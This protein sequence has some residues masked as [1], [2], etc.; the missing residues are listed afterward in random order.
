RHGLEARS[1]LI[2]RSTLLEFE[3][4]SLEAVRAKLERDVALL[5]PERP[6]PDIVEEIARDVLGFAHADDRVV[7]RR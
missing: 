7:T 3:I 5:A 4:K 2:E 6:D 1:R